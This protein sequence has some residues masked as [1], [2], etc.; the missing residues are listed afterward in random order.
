MSPYLKMKG[1]LEDA[2]SALDFEQ[3]VII[4]PGLLVGDR[5]DSR[6]PEYAMRLVAAGLSQISRTYLFD[7]WANPADEVAKATVAAAQKCLD[8]SAPRGKIWT[9]GISDIV[10][11]G[12][13][14][15]KA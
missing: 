8:G 3:V 13:T 7:T 10:R 2:V 15:W 9:L 12:R 14:E 1:E 5:E 4:R 11:L 6:P